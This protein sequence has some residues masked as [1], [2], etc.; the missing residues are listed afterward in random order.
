MRELV[1]EVRQVEEEPALG[2]RHA[3]EVQLGDDAEVL[4]REGGHDGRDER[5][6]DLPGDLLQELVQLMIVG[7]GEDQARRRPPSRPCRVPRRFA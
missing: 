2:E 4:L 5:V 6:A 1:V 3:E 7:L